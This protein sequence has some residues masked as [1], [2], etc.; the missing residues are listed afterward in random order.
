MKYISTETV[1]ACSEQA[2]GGGVERAV[3]RQVVRIITENHHYF[4]PGS[5]SDGYRM[6]NLRPSISSPQRLLHFEAIGYFTAIHMYIMGSAPDPISPLLLLLAVGGIT[7]LH[8]LAMIEKISPSKASILRTWP[9]TPDHLA[10]LLSNDP[11]FHLSSVYLDMT[12][13]DTLQLPLCP[14]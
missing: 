1:L 3:L 7:S 14:G 2:S 5:D 10:T 11:C 6:L 12:V 9:R 8:D 13:S 4:K